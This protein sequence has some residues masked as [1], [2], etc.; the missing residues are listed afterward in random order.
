M[1]KPCGTG[2]PSFVI[3]ARFAPLPPSRYFW[4]RPPS[5]KAYTY[6]IA[7]LVSLFGSGLDDERLG[8]LVVDALAVA[9]PDVPEHGT[10]ADH[11]RDRTE[12]AGERQR[13]HDRYPVVDERCAPPRWRTVDPH[14]F[15]LPEL[16]PERLARPRG[17]GHGVEQREDEHHAGDEQVHR[18]Q[19]V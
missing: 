12:E 9:V 3:S 4:S 14:Q 6:F 15:H 1:V 11:E 13:D 19:L 18:P 16:L 17:H 5:S 8:Q 2:S 10:Q 7:I